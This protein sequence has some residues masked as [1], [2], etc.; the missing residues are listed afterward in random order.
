MVL[1][2]LTAAAIVSAVVGLGY[3]PADLAPSVVMVLTAIFAV[4]AMARHLV[5]RARRK[6]RSEE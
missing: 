3:L 2:P 6:D 5:N 1:P 4:V